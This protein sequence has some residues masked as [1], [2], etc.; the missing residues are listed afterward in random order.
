MTVPDD[1]SAAESAAEEEAIIDNDGVPMVDEDAE[2]RAIFESEEPEEGKSEDETSEGGKAETG[3]DDS[4]KAADATEDKSGKKED[5][6]KPLTAQEKLAQRAEASASGKT[7]P[8]VDVEDAGTDAGGK[9]DDV[10][11]AKDKRIA[12]LE[13]EAEALKKAVSERNKAGDSKTDSTDVSVA[14]IAE[15]ITD[16]AKREQFEAWAADFPEAAENMALMMSFV[17]SKP[18]DDATK[19]E[20]AEVKGVVDNLR[21]EMAAAKAREQQAR[22]ILDVTE[23][24]TDKSG[25]VWPGHTDAVAI[26][27]SDSFKNWIASQPKSIQALGSSYDREDAHAVLDAFKEYS[28][29]SSKRKANEN[30]RTEKEEY[31]SLHGTSMKGS[32]GTIASDKAKRTARS[33]KPMALS[34]QEKEFEGAFTEAVAAR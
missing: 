28:G 33:E 26:V 30:K 13:A 5:D 18:G 10:Q 27:S 14:S 8:D 32:K 31:D 24:W 23:G 12:E 22:F 20:L 6:G 17:T 11:D 1:N 19:K 9:A 25:T 4:N 15:S 3:E 29:A 34:E 2:F 7:L 16:T 21:S